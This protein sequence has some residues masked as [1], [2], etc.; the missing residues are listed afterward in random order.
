MQ[1]EQLQEAA[2]ASFDHARATAELGGVAPKGDP[3]P[4]VHL[5]PETATMAQAC[6]STRLVLRGHNAPVV[7]VRARPSGHSSA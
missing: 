7:K 4:P 3:P 2:R 6:G 1:S 5:L